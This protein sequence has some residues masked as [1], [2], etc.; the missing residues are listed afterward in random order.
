MNGCLFKFFSF[1][2]SGVGCWC[3]SDILVVVVFVHHFFWP[4]VVIA[5][6]TFI[7]ILFEG[8]KSFRTWSSPSR[9]SIGTL[10]LL[11][12]VLNTHTDI[13]MD[14]HT[15]ICIG[16]LRTCA[17][18]KINYFLFTHVFQAFHNWSYPLLLDLVSRSFKLTNNCFTFEKKKKK[19]KKE[20]KKKKN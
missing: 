12:P 1:S 7:G 11:V 17:W 19:K 3:R 9:L 20:T 5:L 8:S 18:K 10:A 4:K 2:V 14:M 16:V 13:H 15:Y 6:L